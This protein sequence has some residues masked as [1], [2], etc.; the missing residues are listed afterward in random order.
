MQGGALFEFDGNFVAMNLFSDMERPIF[1]P[2]DIVFER[3]NHLRT[4]K[5][6]IIFLAMLK[7]VRC[8]NIFLVCSSMFVVAA[9]IVYS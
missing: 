7:L 4:S 9:F 6:K 2:R 3:L 8:A 5:E 1:L